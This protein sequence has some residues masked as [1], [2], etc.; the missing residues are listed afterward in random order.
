MDERVAEM[1]ATLDA[2]REAMMRLAPDASPGGST[3]PSKTERKSDG[4]LG[5]DPMGLTEKILSA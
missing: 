5:A 3:A 4:E 2:T 1:R